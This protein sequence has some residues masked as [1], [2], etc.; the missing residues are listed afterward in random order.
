[1]MLKTSNNKSIFHSFAEGA[2]RKGFRSKLY[3]KKLA[4]WQNKADITIN[5]HQ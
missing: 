1:M 5:D 3:H 4:I 2:A